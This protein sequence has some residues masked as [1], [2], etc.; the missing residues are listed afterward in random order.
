MFASDRQG[1]DGL[2]NI[3]TYLGSIKNT[4]GL[5]LRITLKIDSKV[6]TGF[7]IPSLVW[8]THQTQSLVEVSWPQH[9]MSTDHRLFRSLWSSQGVSCLKSAFPAAY[10]QKYGSG[11]YG[12][13]SMAA[14]AAVSLAPSCCHFLSEMRFGRGTVCSPGWQKFQLAVVTHKASRAD[15]NELW[16]PLSDLWP[17]PTQVTRQSPATQILW[18]MPNTVSYLRKSWSTYP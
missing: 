5:L 1:Y 4:T 13:R 18:F 7:P 17:P 15:C 8:V 14:S 6:S 16:Q 10:L 9:G 2:K 3:S 12:F 11:K